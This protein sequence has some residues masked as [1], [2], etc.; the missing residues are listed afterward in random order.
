MLDGWVMHRPIRQSSIPG[1]RV[2]PSF[3]DRED[4]RGRAT[5]RLLTFAYNREPIVNLHLH[6]QRL[7]LR[8]QKDITE[9]SRSRC[10]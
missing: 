6:C 10:G 5:L 3:A 8:L 1:L 4:L 7:A 9:W 2:R